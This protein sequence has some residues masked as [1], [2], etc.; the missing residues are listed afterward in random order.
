MKAE[1]FRRVLAEYL[2]ERTHVGCSSE[3]VQRLQEHCGFTFE[4][5]Y[6]L[7]LREMGHGAYGFAEGSD[8]ESDALLE[9]QD[10]ASDLL[11]ECGLPPLSKD[12]FWVIYMHQGYLFFAMTVDGVYYYFEGWP[13]L[14]KI[15]DD[16]ASWF[17]LIAKP[18]K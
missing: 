4:E 2:I 1:A 13:F 9:I 17:F 3:E 18:K 16:F 15:C 10:W 11:A 8:Y 14:L 7:F 12:K 5:N 6:I